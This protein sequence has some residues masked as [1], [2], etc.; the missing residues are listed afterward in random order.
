MKV[1]KNKNIDIVNGKKLPGVPETAVVL[2]LAIGEM[3]VD[4]Y[5]QKYKL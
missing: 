1:F 4:R 3:F 5:K 2:E